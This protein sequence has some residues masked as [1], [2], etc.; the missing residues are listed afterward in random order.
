MEALIAF[1]QDYIKL[2]SCFKFYES[3]SA[4]LLSHINVT[5][6]SFIIC[7]IGVISTKWTELNLYS[8][9][10]TLIFVASL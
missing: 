2:M 5:S 7:F 4:F 1:M 8:D 10:K 3:I 9:F 6:I